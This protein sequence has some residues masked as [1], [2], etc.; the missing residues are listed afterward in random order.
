MRTLAA[1][2]VLTA[3]PAFADEVD[4]QLDEVAAIHGEAGPWATMGYRMA[5]FAMKKL[6]VTA[7]KGDLIVEHRSPRAVQFACVADGVQAASK[8]SVGKLSLSWSEAKVDD[9]QTIFTRPSTG[10]KVVLKPSA[11]FRET[12]LNTPREKAR[13]N[14]R[15][16][17]GLKDAELFDE[18]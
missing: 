10:A 1:V 17:M 3:M 9:A 11:K 7:G 5:Q 8:V 13:E 14:A 12:F 2:L 18:V 15:K 4:K 16:V 6:G